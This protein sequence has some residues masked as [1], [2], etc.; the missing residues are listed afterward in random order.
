LQFRARVVTNYLVHLLF[1]DESG[2]LDQPGFFALGGIA[3]RDHDW[4]ALGTG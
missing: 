3:L 1:L 4:R 2:Q